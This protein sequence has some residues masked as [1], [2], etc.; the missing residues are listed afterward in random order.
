MRYSQAC[1]CTKHTAT[2]RLKPPKK[3]RQKTHMMRPVANR[4]EASRNH[5]HR[6]TSPSFLRRLALSEDRGCPAGD[7]PRSSHSRP[8][9]ECT[10]GKEDAD[11]FSAGRRSC[12]CDNRTPNTRK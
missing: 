1:R 12:T 11:C 4:N 10:F 9:T 7:K 5:R 6:P 3:T 8:H 2:K